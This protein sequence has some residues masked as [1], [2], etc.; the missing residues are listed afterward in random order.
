MTALVKR[1]DSPERKILQKVNGVMTVRG[2]CFDRETGKALDKVYIQVG[3]RIIQPWRSQRL[4][5]RSKYP[6]LFASELPK[7]EVNFGY[8][9]HFQMG[10]GIKLVRV[11]GVFRGEEVVLHSR[12]VWFSR[13]L[14]KVQL[15]KDYSGWVDRFDQI[16]QDK[17]AL[18]RGEEKFFRIKPKISLL[19]PTY[20]TPVK[21]LSRCIDSVLEQVYENWELCI[22]D[23]ASSSQQLLSLLQE[24][25]RRDER[26]KI[27][28]RKENGHISEA[29]NSALRL[30]SGEWIGLVDHDD[31]LRPHALHQ[32]VKY[33]NRYP[34][35]EFFYSDEDKVD[36]DGKR[37]SPHFKTGWNPEMLLG[38]NYLCHFCLFRRSSLE[39]IGGFRK[40]FEGVQ[41]WDVFLRITEKLSS[42]QIVHIPEVLYHWRA[43]AGSTA[44][45][46]DAKDYVHAAARKMLEDYL[47][48]N[49]LRGQLQPV[50]GGHWR[51]KWADPA[52][53]PKVCII[54]PTKDQYKVLRNCLNSIWEK[55]TYKH[56]H[57]LIIDNDSTDPKSISYLQSLPQDKVQVIPFKEPFNYSRINNFAVRQ[58]EDEFILL[59]NND[60]EVINPDWLSELVRQGVRD[61]VG[62]VGAKLLYPDDTVQHAGVVLGVGGVAGHWQKHKRDG[63]YGYFNHLN[64]VRA[65]SA[66][67]GA[68]MLVR[69]KV[70]EEVGGLEE[71]YLTVAFNDVDFCLKVR[72]AGYRNIYT[73]FARLYH[74]ESKSRG[75]DESAEKL[76]RFD[77]EMRYMKWKWGRSIME[78]PLHNPN[79]SLSQEGFSFAHPPHHHVYEELF[80]SDELPEAEKNFDS[81]G[82]FPGKDERSPCEFIVAGFERGGTTLVSDILRANGYE[83]GFECGVLL[84]PSPREFGKIKPYS[85]WFLGQ[86]GLPSDERDNFLQKDFFTFYDD[87]T[88]RAFPNFSGRG[89]FDKTP[90]YM[91]CLGDVLRRTEFVQKAVVIY[92]DPRAVFVSRAKREQTESRDEN[93]EDFIGENLPILVSYYLT[94]FA[95]CISHRNNPN[96]LFL[97][98]EGLCLRPQFWLRK[99]GLFLAGEPFV[100]KT[101]EARFPNVYGTSISP[102][103]VFAFR[104]FISK[105]MSDRILRQTALAAPFFA[106]DIH[107]EDYAYPWLNF[108]EKARHCLRKYNLPEYNC[109]AGE[110]FFDPLQFLLKHQELLDGSRNPVSVF[111]E[112]KKKS[113]DLKNL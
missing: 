36:E 68:C 49:K 16:T 39:A 28:Y 33:R 2:W 83:S 101:L 18:W 108:I 12:L 92:R 72:E 64:L 21:F 5:L 94:Y 81:Q 42:R 96:V 77:L 37:F 14:S 52:D 6:E 32:F 79:I 88:Q 74:H 71:N 78:D 30:A 22:A 3:R 102:E 112:E 76:A 75:K 65:Y 110:F 70:Y 31:E 44:T 43:I 57:I 103:Y 59:L 86:W 8:E 1:L 56:Y 20:N 54:I 58:T 47:R 27:I 41:D 104:E 99:L 46:T 51:I 97:P 24:Y 63:A 34:A 106:A 73:P 113:A 4:D 89:F 45:S 84:A 55:T 91:K 48:R 85:D 7:S 87:L 93:L 19:M 10:N 9:A 105:E 109:A 15:R 100:E 98:F 17:I 111:I 61:G 62:C 90:A 38:Q 69:K 11:I 53:E 40:G 95:G 23:D 13:S 80:L 67:T 25:E 50:K 29:T 66:V 26:I 107:S 82:G 35:G 60:V